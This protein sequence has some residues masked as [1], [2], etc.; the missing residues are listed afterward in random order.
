MAFPK[1]STGARIR[2]AVAIQNSSPLLVR[3]VS[4]AGTSTA[5]RLYKVPQLTGV[6]PKDVAVSPTGHTWGNQTIHH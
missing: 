4:L 3:S 5:V 6:V 2:G 1:P